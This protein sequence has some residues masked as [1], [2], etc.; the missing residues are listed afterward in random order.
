MNAMINKTLR[1]RN[2]L[3]KGVTW[4]TPSVTING[5]ASL[6][7]DDYECPVAESGEDENGETTFTYTF[8]YP[9]L[10][11]EPTFSLDDVL[12]FTFIP[13]A[14]ATEGDLTELE[15]STGEYTVIK[16][17]LVQAYSTSAG[18]SATV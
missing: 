2:P 11:E 14:D 9:I 13:K 4:W 7:L 16:D 6:T 15:W 18:V 8:A 5:G 12:V 3:A 10:I 1:I 17:N